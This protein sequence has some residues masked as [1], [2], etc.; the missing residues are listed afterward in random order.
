MIQAAVLNK[1]HHLE[2]SS[3]DFGNL[4][5]FKQQSKSTPDKIL[6]EIHN[7]QQ[8]TKLL[9][10]QCEKLAYIHTVISLTEK[11]KR[12]LYGRILNVTSAGV[13]NIH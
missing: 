4:L 8:H 7:S 2:R 13:L 1:T 11:M 5:S 10:N 6:C 3:F 9:Q 12:K